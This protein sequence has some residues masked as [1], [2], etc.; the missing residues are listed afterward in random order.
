[1]RASGSQVFLDL[2]G[3]SDKAILCHC[4]GNVLKNAGWIWRIE[5]MKIGWALRITVLIFGITVFCGIFAFGF[6]D[7]GGDWPYWRGPEA[8][9]MA[10]GDAPL[11]WT[12][13][14]NVRWKTAIPGRGNSSPVL[15]GDKIFITTAV[16]TGAASKKEPAPKS[17]RGG[18]N[19][20][21]QGPQ[22]EHRFDVLCIDRKTGKVL[23]QR[24]AK[25]AV[26]HEGYHGTYGSFASNSPVTDGKHVYAFFGSRGIYTYDMDGNLVWEKDF[27]VQMKMRMAFGEGMAPVLSGDRLILVFDHEGDSFMSV[28]DKNS[29]KEIWRVERDE[30]T[31]WAAPLVVEY[32]GRKQII[33]AGS[34]KV[35]SYDFNTGELIWECGGLGANTIPQPVSQDDLVFVMTGYRNPNLMAIRLGRTGDLTGTDAVVWNQTRGNSYT[36]SP[37]LYDNKLYV[38]T[39]DAMVSC[40]NASTGEPY[41]HQ[42][43][44]PKTYSFKSSPVGANDKLYLASEN[45][46]VVVLRMGEKFEVLATN[47]MKDQMF[48]ATPAISRGEIFLRSQNTLF[49]ISD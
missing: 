29:G 26:P 11:H 8:N 7:E 25:T 39:D 23:W 41:Y 2:S 32:Q 28:L 27:G 13:T 49:C 47:T 38:L 35:R 36:P 44:L 16:P 48:I 22:A 18:F 14:E 30:A 1:V 5:R 20:A 6:L 46:D 3:G 34:N 31:N 43:R 10:I 15:W 4:G 9:G 19:A 45:E 42:T 40:Y 24:T 37:V 12:D 21:A 33:T 17:G